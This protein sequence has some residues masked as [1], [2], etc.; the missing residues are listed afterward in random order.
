MSKFD[1]PHIEFKV[2]EYSEDGPGCYTIGV[3]RIKPNDGGLLNKAG[4]RSEFFVYAKL[5]GGIE[6][7]THDIFELDSKVSALDDDN[8]FTLL[9][10]VENDGKFTELVHDMTY[11]PDKIDEFIEE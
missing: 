9:S 2:I 11:T 1:L 3:F 8:L 5:D 10:A 6:F 4:W 7:A